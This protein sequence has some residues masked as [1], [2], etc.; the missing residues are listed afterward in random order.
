MLCHPGA[1]IPLT[2]GTSTAATSHLAPRP[3]LPPAA[4]M[5]TLGEELFGHLPDLPA[6]GSGAAALPLAHVAMV[7]TRDGGCLLGLRLSHLVA[8]FGTLRCLLRHVAREYNGLPLAP[9]DVPGPSQPALAALEAAPPPLGAR[10]HNYVPLPPSFGE[11]LAAL[12]GQP[13]L[14]G[15]TLHLPAARLAALKSQAAAEAAAEAGGEELGEAWV[16]TQ[17][18]VIG[19]LWRTLAALPCRRGA[20]VG[21]H[22]AMDI[23]P[24]LPGAAQ[25]AAGGAQGAAPPRWVYG[26]LVASALTPPLDVTAMSLGAVALELRRTVA[27]WGLVCLGVGGGVRVWWGGGLGWWVK[28]IGAVGSGEQWPGACAACQPACS[29]PASPPVHQG[30]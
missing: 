20:I 30:Q 13:P 7:A 28:G 12:A 23:R 22:Q 17:A 26:S 8:D 1:G 4:P 10:L 24:R 14:R 11:Q 2:L 9:E 15:L 16:S 25:A 29:P 6:H 3:P 21:L 18:A 19:W 27:R 5:A